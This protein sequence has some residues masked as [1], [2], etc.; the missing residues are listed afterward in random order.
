MATGFKGLDRLTNGL[1]NSDLILLAARPGVGKTSF[2]MNV[3]TNIA[4]TQKKRCAIFSLEMPKTQLAQR[5]LCSVACVSMA[6]ALKGELSVD[7]W[8]AIWAG[9]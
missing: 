2:A 8:K 9:K 7:E 3:V 6:K 4:I 1:Q 5:A